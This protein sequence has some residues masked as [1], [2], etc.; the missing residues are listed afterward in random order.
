MA[1]RLVGVI[2]VSLC[3]GLLL[4]VSQSVFAQ[5]DAKLISPPPRPIPAATPQPASR[6]PT[7]LTAASSASATT[8]AA[9]TDG[10]SGLKISKGA[11]ILPNDQGQIWREYDISPYTLRVRDV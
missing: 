2:R 5:T 1:A 6:P 3:A 10:R 8:A 11:G 9:A 7:L 4:L